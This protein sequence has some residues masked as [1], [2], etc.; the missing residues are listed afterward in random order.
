V[1]R[2]VKTHKPEPGAHPRNRESGM[3]PLILTK[4]EESLESRVAS[5]GREGTKRGRTF[6]HSRGG[7]EE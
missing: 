3:I 2:K 4:R 7:V 1:D 6:G 5:G